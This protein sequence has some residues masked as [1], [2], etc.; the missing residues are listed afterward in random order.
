MTSTGCHNQSH[1]TI[2]EQVKSRD[3][4]QT[5]KYRRFYGTVSLATIFRLSTQSEL[6]FK[7][8]TS[9]HSLAICSSAQHYDDVIMGL[10]ASQII[11]LTIVYSTI[12]SAADQRKHQSSASLSF[13]WGIHRGP[14][15]YPHK[16]PVTRKMFP[17]D[18]V[19]MKNDLLT[20][21]QLW[22]YRIVT[23]TLATKTSSEIRYENTFPATD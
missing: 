13:V 11:I 14:V 15:N 6:Q 10:M 21:G 17:F 12:Y 1:G 19:I 18:V 4:F 23:V 22:N 5:T 20:D 8:G 2:C 16:W 7:Q 9:Q 3:L